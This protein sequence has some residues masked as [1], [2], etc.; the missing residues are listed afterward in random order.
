MKFPGTLF[1]GW[2]ELPT[3]LLSETEQLTNFFSRIK[4][5]KLGLEA[6]DSMTH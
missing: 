6:L 3:D 2:K 1:K 5:P 4:S